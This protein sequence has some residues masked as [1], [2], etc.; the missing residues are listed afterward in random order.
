MKPLLFVLGIFAAI[1]ASA[2][3]ATQSV[4]SGGRWCAEYNF[5]GGGSSRNCGFESF[6]QCL[7]TVTGAG[8]SCSPD[9]G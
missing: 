1:C 2:G 6:Q 3:C 4:Q 5:D 8:G 9:R 7:A